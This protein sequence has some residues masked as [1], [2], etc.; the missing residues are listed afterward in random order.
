MTFRQPSRKT[1]GSTSRRRKYSLVHPSASPRRPLILFFRREYP[2]SDLED[3]AIAV[4]A[5]YYLQLLLHIDD[6]DG[7]SYEP[8]LPALGSI[9]GMEKR[10]EGDL[11]QWEAHR[12][13]PFFVFD[14]Q[15]LVGQDEMSIMNGR[16]AHEKTNAAWRLYFDNQPGKAVAAFGASIGTCYSCPVRARRLLTRYRRGQTRDSLSSSSAYPEEAETTLSGRTLQRCRAGMWRASP[17]LSERP[18]V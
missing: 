13:T 4:E 5:S 16:K 1:S 6:E 8:L 7:K 15:T 17:A 9:T 11:D 12:I 18:C 3:C 2:I 10:I 14:G